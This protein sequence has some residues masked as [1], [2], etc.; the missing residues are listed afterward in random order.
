MDVIG[1]FEN[2]N[3]PIE[4]ADTEKKTTVDMEIH[5]E[6]IKKYVK[7]LKMI[8]INLKKL[9]SLVYGNCTKSVQTM[10]KADAEHEQK[11]CLVKS[12]PSYQ[13]SILK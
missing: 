2:K 9:Y 3:K 7:D 11:S 6:E 10:L 4:L 13:D 8:K 5:K 12:R 1:D